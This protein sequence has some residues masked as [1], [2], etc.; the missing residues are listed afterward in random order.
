[1]QRR[2]R[3]LLLLSLVAGACSR[4]AV[5][6]EVIPNTVTRIGNFAFRECSTLTSIDIPNSVT[7]S[8]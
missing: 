7:R 8:V 5:S 2:F 4:E 6:P 3:F 1:M